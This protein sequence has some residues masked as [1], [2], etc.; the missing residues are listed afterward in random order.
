MEL[1]RMVEQTQ[2]LLDQ[3]VPEMNAEQLAVAA[4]EL[5]KKFR[6][7]GALAAVKVADLIK[8]KMAKNGRQ[9][10]SADVAANVRL[11]DVAE[12]VGTGVL[13]KIEEHIKG[14]SDCPIIEVH[15][16]QTMTA[17]AQILG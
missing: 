15:D 1:T 6:A 17:L 2:K 11:S 8:I 12:I 9:L 7:F 14:G 13:M 3:N 16:I 4:Q 10:T 5:D